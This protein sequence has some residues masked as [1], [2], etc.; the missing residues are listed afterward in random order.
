MD[1]KK[2]YFNFNENKKNRCGKQK[3]YE[4]QKD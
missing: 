2:H 3:A 4:I 1:T